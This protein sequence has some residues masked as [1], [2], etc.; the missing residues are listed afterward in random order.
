MTRLRV[1][2]HYLLI[3]TE[4]VF[5]VWPE[6]VPPRDTFDHRLSILWG[7]ILRKRL[8]GSFNNSAFCSLPNCQASINTCWF[9]VVLCLPGGC[10]GVHCVA[11][12]PSFQVTTS[13]LES[14]LMHRLPSLSPWISLALISRSGHIPLMCIV[15][16]R[17]LWV[18]PSWLFFYI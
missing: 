16:H 5:T 4:V 13:N 11:L 18:T 10:T 6:W 17:L 3:G 14:F 7:Y 9:P 1:L 8:A 12:C 15:P 2:I